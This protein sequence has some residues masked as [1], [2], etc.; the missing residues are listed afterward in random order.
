MKS[1]LLNYQVFGAFSLY[2]LYSHLMIKLIRVSGVEVAVIF[3]LTGY[4]LTY[5]LPGKQI[6][7]APNLN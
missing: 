5:D 4:K 7:I 6:S 1:Y 3:N 2:V